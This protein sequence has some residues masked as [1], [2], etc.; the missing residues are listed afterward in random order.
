MSCKKQ[1][2]MSMLGQKTG[3]GY[4][5]AHAERVKCIRFN[6]AASTLAGQPAASLDSSLR[7]RSSHQ[8]D[9]P[10][11][12]STQLGAAPII[13]AV[14][15]FFSLLNLEFDNQVNLKELRRIPTQLEVDYFKFKVSEFIFN[16]NKNAPPRN[17]IKVQLR[18][19]SKPSKA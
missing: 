12:V 11:V 2:P 8:L 16:L 10:P 13:F 3:H 18:T 9:Q 5:N 1:T 4:L 19:K 17:L 14:S 6:S 7:S 15:Y